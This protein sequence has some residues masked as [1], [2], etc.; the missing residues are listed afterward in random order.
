MIGDYARDKDG[1]AAVMALCEAA[2]YYKSKNKTLWDAMIDIYE[3]YG[4][5]K[6]KQV[7]I[8]REGS[9]G[10]QEIKDMMTK[11]R[12]SSIDKIGEYKVLTFKDVEEDVVTGAD[13]PLTLIVFI[14]FLFQF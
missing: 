5:Y 9:Q 7:S 2:C 11:M 3:K 4:Y 6:E 12:K 8:V 10:A 13:C 1:I 14:V